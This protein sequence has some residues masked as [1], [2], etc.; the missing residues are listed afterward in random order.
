MARVV[1]TA[2]HAG[3]PLTL[4]KAGSNVLM[5]DAGIEGVVMR[6]CGNLSGVSIHGDVIRVL[7]G[8]ADRELAQAA[9]RAGMSGLEFLEDI[10]GTVGGALVQNAEAYGT[11]ISDHLLD[12]TVCDARGRSLTLRRSELGFGYRDSTFK[13][14]GD[15]VIVEARLAPAGRDDP[16]AIAA[17]MD[18]LRERRRARYPLDEP[19]CGSVF[20]RPE[21]DYAGRLVEQAGLGGLSVGGA[22]VSTLHHNF[23]VNSGGATAADVRA[24]VERVTAEVQ[25]RFGVRL[26]RELVYLGRH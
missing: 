11:A 13:R 14:T 22:R 18:A 20:K 6:L 15:L 16:A 23:I 9:A 26:E 1:D 7:A 5:P 25:S 8:T 24:L 10:P 21:G 12:V 17:R 3:A 2:Q 19:S 4:L